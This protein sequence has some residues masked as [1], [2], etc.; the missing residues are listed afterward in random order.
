M[1]AFLGMPIPEPVAGKLYDGIAGLRSDLQ[2]IKWVNPGN[3]HVTILFFGEIDENECARVSAAMDM[4][5]CGGVTEAALS[6]VSQFPLR[7]NPRV[8]YAGLKSGGDCCQRVFTHMSKSLPE[9][10]SRR[11]YTPH[12]TLGRVRRGQR[13]VFDGSAVT[14]PED[15]FVLNEVVLY[16]SVLHQTGAEYIRIHSKTLEF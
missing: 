8:V 6:G 11:K 13:V 9:Y 14:L 7:G 15:T 4:L 5:S 12:I 16:R 1:R 10:A 3:Y 2:G